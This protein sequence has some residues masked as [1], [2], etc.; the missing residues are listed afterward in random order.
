MTDC[1]KTTVMEQINEDGS[2]TVT[3]N[4]CP[5]CYKCMQHVTSDIGGWIENVVQNR[6]SHEGDKI[7]RNEIDKHIQSGTV[8]SDMTKSS[9]ILDSVIPVS[10]IA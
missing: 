9:L 10:N 8:S 3:L 5:V 7:Y 6:T 1:I 4:L 2:L